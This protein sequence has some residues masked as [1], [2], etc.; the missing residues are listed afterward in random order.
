MTILLTLHSIVRWLTILT[1]AAALIKLTLGLT[2][3]QAFDKLAS[4][5]TGAFSGLMD[6]QLLLGG[7]FFLLS[8]AAIPGGFS[9]RY[10]W[11]HLSLML[12][13]VILAHLPAM[14]KKQADNLRYRN[15]LFAVLGALILVALGVSL[16]PGNRWTRISGLF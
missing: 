4:G 14:W 10:R 5:L 15:T 16:L 7:F 6:T 1:A 3:K 12:V 8:G 2:Q 11:E 9:L 13:A